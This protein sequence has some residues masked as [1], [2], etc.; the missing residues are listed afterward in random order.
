MEYC[1]SIIMNLKCLNTFVPISLLM[2]DSTCTN[3]V[4]ANLFSIIMTQ[5]LYQLERGIMDNI[6]VTWLNS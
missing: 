6:V 2:N 3:I 4:S 1:Y 5:L